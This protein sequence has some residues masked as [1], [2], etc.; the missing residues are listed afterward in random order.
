[1]LEHN[2]ILKLLVQNHAI[3]QLDSSRSAL[4]ALTPG[5]NL[6]RM[7]LAQPLHPR[8]VVHVKEVLRHQ[9]HTFLKIYIQPHTL[10]QARQ[11]AS[12]VTAR[13]DLCLVDHDCL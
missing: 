9:A 11:A 3:K 2:H 7:P 5:H 1:V 10:L 8:K 12:Q 13:L 6:L 4:G